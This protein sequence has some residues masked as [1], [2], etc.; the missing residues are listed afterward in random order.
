MPR[1][2]S[3]PPLPQPLGENCECKHFRNVIKMAR[4]TKS[5]APLHCP[6]SLPPLLSHVSCDIWFDTWIAILASDCHTPAPF[7]TL[8]HAPFAAAT[9]AVDSQFTRL[10]IQLKI[11]KLFMRLIEILAMYVCVKEYE[12][13][14]VGGGGSK[15]V[16]VRVSLLA[17]HILN[18]AVNFA[19]RLLR[20]TRFLTWLKVAS[21][22]THTNTS[23]WFA[24]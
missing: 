17:V 11:E 15:C 19:Y 4:A 18:L 21:T 24:R 14:Y 1:T 20:S 10:R 2:P 6:R 22:H 5:V 3:S 8:L 16:C 13:V 23:H 12:C 7:H 9:A